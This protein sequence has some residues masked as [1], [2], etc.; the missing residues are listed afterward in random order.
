MN[1]TRQWSSTQR[2]GRHATDGECTD[3]PGPRVLARSVGVGRSRRE[4]TGRRPRRHGADAAGTRVEGRRPV[5][6]HLRRPRGR[7]QAGTRGCRAPGR[8]RRPQRVRVLRLRG[9]RPGAGADRG[10][11]LRRYGAREAAAR[12]GVHRCREAARLGIDR[13]G[14]EPHRPERRAEGDVPRAGRAGSRRHASRGLHVHERC[15]PGYPLDHHR[16]RLLG[17]GLPEVREGASRVGVPRRHPRA[18][19]RQLDRPA[20][21][22]LA[23]VVETGGAREDHRRRR[24]R[25]PATAR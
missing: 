25:P 5:L 2:I 11:G 8:P 22:P 3:H 24:D 9:E 10:D 20:D 12:P 4:A 21:Q 16:D 18:A 6:D 7:D 1:R 23:D 15:P 17:R 13:R 19:K 14:G